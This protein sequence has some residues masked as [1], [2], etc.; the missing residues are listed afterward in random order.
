[1]PVFKSRFNQQTNFTPKF[2]HTATNW[3]I[4]N[5]EN[6]SFKKNAGSSKFPL[7]K[8][9]RIGA[10]QVLSTTDSTSTATADFKLPDDSELLDPTSTIKQN[11]KA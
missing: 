1:M 10:N 4:R 2:S 5:L 3:T 6:N 11:R 9:R 8:N 7:I